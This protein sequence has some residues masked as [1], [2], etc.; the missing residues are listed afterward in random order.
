MVVFLTAFTFDRR[1]FSSL[2]Y[3]VW[4]GPLLMLVME[5]TLPYL[6]ELRYNTL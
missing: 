5:L 6:I 3:T 2:P 1:R 4:H